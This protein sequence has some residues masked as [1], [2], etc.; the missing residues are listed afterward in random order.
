MIMALSAALLGAATF[1]ILAP[2]LGWSEESATG[3][4]VNPEN[5]DLLATRQE[6]L[7]AIKDLEMEFQVGKLT[8]E[9]FRL[10]RE[11]LAREA[12]ELFKRMDQPDKDSVPSSV[13]EPDAV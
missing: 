3:I 11:Q 7:S 6:I 9:D 8:E 13:K 5:A 10:T 12:V 1:W 2:L 4:P